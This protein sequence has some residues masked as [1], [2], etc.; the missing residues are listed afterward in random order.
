MGVSK[1]VVPQNGWS[2][3][4]NP[5]KM[6]AL[7]VPHLGMPSNVHLIHLLAP[8][9]GTPPKESLCELGAGTPPTFEHRLPSFEI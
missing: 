6:D 7:G 3:M 1:I 5:I 8:P 9:T 2:I 4:E